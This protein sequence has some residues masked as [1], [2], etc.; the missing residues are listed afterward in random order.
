MLRPRHPAIVA[1]PR[2]CRNIARTTY[3]APRRVS[4]R[5]SLFPHGFSATEHLVPPSEDNSTPVTDSLPRSPLL[6]PTTYKRKQIKHRAAPPD[7]SLEPLTAFEQSILENPFGISLLILLLLLLLTFF[8][9]PFRSVSLLDAENSQTPSLANSTRSPR[10]TSP[11]TKPPPQ[12]H[13]LLRPRRRN[14]LAHAV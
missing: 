1:C 6:D 12:I 9:L 2:G 4:A 5:K 3:R 10:R 13:H 7:K 14:T 11:P 8:L